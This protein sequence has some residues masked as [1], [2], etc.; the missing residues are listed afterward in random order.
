M[1]LNRNTVD[2]YV[3]PGKEVG[4]KADVSLVPETNYFT[5]ESTATTGAPGSRNTIWVSRPLGR[6]IIRVSGSIAKDAKVTGRETLRSVAEPQLYAG[7]VLLTALGK[8]GV[9]VLGEMTTAR[10]PEDSKLLAVHKSPPLSRILSLLNKPS[11]NLIA[12]VLLKYIGAY[13]KG[14]GSASGGAAVEEEFFKRIGM[15][16][17]GISIADGSGLSRLNYISANNLIVLLDY[18]HTAKHS[19]VF[20]DSLPIAG[21]D[22]GLYSRM[23]DTRA[24]KNVRAKTGYINRVS[25]LSG[26]VNTKSG[27]P[28]AFSILMN[29]HKCPNSSATAIQNKICALLADLP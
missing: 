26:Y 3:K 21:V 23:R 24:N 22:G 8:C 1:N 20:V 19:K 25:S 2:I 29:H 11:D 7:H 5:I 14:D 10:L 17:D 13:V 9:E 6:N 15:D 28:L 12:E 18:M 16:M 4:D 27:E